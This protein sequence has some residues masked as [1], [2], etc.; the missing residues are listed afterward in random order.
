MI[1][2][3]ISLNVFFKHILGAHTLSYLRG[4]HVIVKIITINTINKNNRKNFYY[5]PQLF[6]RDTP[7]NK[8]HNNKNKQTTGKFYCTPHYNFQRTQSLGCFIQPVG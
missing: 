6:K 4:V 1:I 5:T 2:V 7:C 3:N 8:N